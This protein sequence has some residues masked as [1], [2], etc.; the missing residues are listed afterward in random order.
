MNKGNL[1]F[2]KFSCHLRFHHLWT[3]RITWQKARARPNQQL[4]D[5]PLNRMICIQLVSD[6]VTVGGQWLAHYGV[7]VS[8]GPLLILY[9]W[10]VFLW[11]YNLTATEEPKVRRPFCHT[12]CPPPGACGSQ[13]PRTLHC[14]MWGWGD[15]SRCRRQVKHFLSVSHGWFLM[16]RLSLP[17]H[18]DNV[19][20]PQ[21]KHTSQDLF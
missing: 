13:A 20:L 5:C 19:T 17:F 3:W 2:G 6:C 21:G 15:V 9:H 14:L 18:V 16:G 10:G 4:K 12:L 1:F 8:Q 7:S 11:S